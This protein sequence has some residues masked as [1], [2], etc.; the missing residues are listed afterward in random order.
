VLKTPTNPTKPNGRHSSATRKPPRSEVKVKAER[1]TPPLPED[2]DD[3][4]SH[5]V[6]RL[7]R[8]SYRFRPTS[9]VIVAGHTLRLAEH[10]EAAGPEVAEI[11]LDNVV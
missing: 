9:N 6:E 1:V 5:T 2:S 4:E 7:Y 3:G 10:G 8:L 11:M